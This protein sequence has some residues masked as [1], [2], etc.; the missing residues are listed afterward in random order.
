[1]LNSCLISL[2]IGGYVVIMK[3]VIRSHARG[4]FAAIG[5]F[6]CIVSLTPATAEEGLVLYSGRS[7]TL[8]EPIIEQ[9]EKDT[10]IKVTARFGGTAELAIAIQEEGRHSPADVFWAQDAGALGAL[11]ND[12]ALQRLPHDVIQKVPEVFR[13]SNGLWVA[14]SG[15]ARVLAY[16]P[17][18]VEESQLPKSLHNLTDPKWKG[19]VGWAPANGSFQTFV[20]A[21][22]ELEGRDATLQWLRAMRANGAKAYP[23]NTPIIEAIAAGEIDLGLP[24]HYYLLRFQA[25]DSKYP[26]AQTFFETGSAGNLVNVAGVGLLKTSQKRELALRFV[27]YILSAKAQ[28]YFTSQVFEYPVTDEAIPSAQLV[29]LEE[30]VRIAPRIDLEDLA[31]LKGTLKLL[32]E[33]GV[34]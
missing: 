27:K 16:S 10:G 34:L 3:H 13:N 14:T 29:S 26:V 12:G 31:D 7:R 23:K 17:G 4:A 22:I 2:L 30:L 32:A 18:R 28:Q 19:R 33:A 15:R 20:T 8:V 24:N 21:M 9:F 1:M 11:A 25:A 6:A 5:F